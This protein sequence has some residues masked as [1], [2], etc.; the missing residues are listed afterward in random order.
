MKWTEAPSWINRR[1]TLKCFAWLPVKLASGK[2]VW[3]EPYLEVGIHE[4]GY[5][6]YGWTV[7][8]RYQDTSHKI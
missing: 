4:V 5:D 3:L 8:R 7:L 1:R 6:D 2:T